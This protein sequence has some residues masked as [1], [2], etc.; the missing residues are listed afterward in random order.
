MID[1]IDYSK[2]KDYLENREDFLFKLIDLLD[3]ESLEL[4]NEIVDL[5][6]NSLYKIDNLIYRV[7]GLRR[8]LNE[9]AE[10]FAYINEIELSSYD[11]AA[12][13]F[14]LK[15][16]LTAMVSVYAFLAN[17]LLGITA[18]VMLNHKASTDFCDEIEEI[19]EKVKRFNENDIYKIRET[20]NNCGRILNGKIK[21]MEEDIKTGD[22]IDNYGEAN[23]Y[24]NLYLYNKIDDDY[25]G[26]L[27]ETTTIRMIEL[28]KSDL[29][30]DSNNIYELLELAQSKKENGKK[31]FKEYR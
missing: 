10:S 8:L 16:L 30:S 23:Q 31:L 3:K 15:R 22:L 12:R 26:K 17:A 13:R 4:F 21:K 14:Q 24:I 6:N 20:I 7:E 5:N 25:I 9:T 27:S 28:L 29:N 11:F 1:I 18:F 19:G 2:G